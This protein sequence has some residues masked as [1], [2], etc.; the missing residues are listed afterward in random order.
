[1]ILLLHAVIVMQLLVSI[2]VIPFRY[3]LHMHLNLLKVHLSTYIAES[4]QFSSHGLCVK[5]C[6]PQAAAFTSAA[7]PNRAWQSKM[8]GMAHSVCHLYTDISL[9]FDVFGA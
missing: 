7:A 3:L 4:E 5:L 6:Q 8:C 2:V 1:M 9:N